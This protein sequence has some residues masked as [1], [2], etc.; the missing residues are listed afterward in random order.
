MR[1]FF[2]NHLKL[3]NYFTLQKH[4]CSNILEI[5]PLKNENFQTKNSDI[6]HIS[7]QNIDSEYSL[8]PPR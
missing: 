4:D 1:S 3:E 8:E 7:V 2:S 6:F 5:S